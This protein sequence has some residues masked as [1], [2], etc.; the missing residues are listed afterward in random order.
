MQMLSELEGV[1]VVTN[2][3]ATILQRGLCENDEG[4]LNQCKVWT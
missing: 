1:S 4:P 3:I 2:M